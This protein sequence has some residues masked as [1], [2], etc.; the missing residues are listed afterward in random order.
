MSTASEPILTP[1]TSLITILYW[2][3]WVSNAQP[4]SA[5]LNILINGI[6]LIASAISTISEILET[7]IFTGTIWS[8]L[9]LE[10]FA[11]CQCICLSCVK[12]HCI[13][14]ASHQ[15]TKPINLNLSR[16]C[17]MIVNSPRITWNPCSARAMAVALPIPEDAYS[18]QQHTHH[19]A[20]WSSTGREWGSKEAFF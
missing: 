8:V 13:G 14:P 5:T 4:I 12:E 15:I 16:I 10:P 17:K 11:V 3:L 20:F 1:H 7:W 9:T 6:Y 18:F 2:G 19:N